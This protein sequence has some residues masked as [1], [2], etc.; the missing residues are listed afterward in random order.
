[1]KERELREHAECDFC[2][3]KIGACR[4]PGFFTV[5]VVMYG[6]EPEALQRNAGLAMMIGAPLAMHMGPDEDLATERLRTK[7]TMCFKCHGELMPE[8]LE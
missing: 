6:L 4:V 2:G 5:E 3:E 7:K 1:M 8:P